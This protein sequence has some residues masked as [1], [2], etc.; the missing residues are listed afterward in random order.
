MRWAAREGA[1]HSAQENVQSDAAM[2]PSFCFY[3]LSFGLRVLYCW[4]RFLSVWFNVLSL[5]FHVLSLAIGTCMGCMGRPTLSLFKFN[6]GI[7]LVTV[8]HLASRL[9]RRVYYELSLDLDRVTSTWWGLI[10]FA[11][12][13]S[14]PRF[15]DLAVSHYLRSGRNVG[16]S[17]F[18]I[19]KF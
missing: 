9:F 3:V 1:K 2:F 5:G 7:F 16:P 10:L 18:S 6:S 12:C 17:R 14:R 15:A 4:L 8:F 19:I 13:V 11:S